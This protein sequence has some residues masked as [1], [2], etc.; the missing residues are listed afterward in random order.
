MDEYS[1]RFPDQSAAYIPSCDLTVT[2]APSFYL[3]QLL[4]GGYRSISISIQLEHPNGIAFLLRISSV[5]SNA[6]LHPIL[7][8]LT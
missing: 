1:L 7:A 8:F 5:L 6:T 3:L 4:D 2:V